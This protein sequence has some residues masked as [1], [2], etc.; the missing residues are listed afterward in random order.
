MKGKSVV[1]VARDAAPSRCFTRL[2]ESLK[3]KGIEAVL[4]VGDGKLINQDQEEIEEAITSSRIVFLGMSSTKE[5]AEVEIIAGEAA[6]KNNIPFGFYGDALHSWN[7]ARPGEFFDG[8]A[9]LA[10]FYFGLTEKDAQDARLVFPKAL[11][12][13]TGNPLRE[14]MIFPKLPREEVRRRLGIKGNEKLI[15]SGGGKF[16]GGNLACWAIIMQELHHLK[17]DFD[18]QLVLSPH[19]GDRVLSAFDQKENKPLDV[20]EELA[21][22]SP[23]PTRV[24]KNMMASE[25]VPGSDLVIDPFTSIALEAAALEIPVIS[26]RLEILFLLKEKRSG[27]RIVEAID[28]GLSELVY[29]NQLKEAVKRLLTSE[30][31]DLM[32]FR[33]KKFFPK[34]DKR[35]EAIGKMVEAIN[36]FIK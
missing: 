7:R 35:G 1:L 26:L 36:S 30:G 33:Q 2:E 21:S 22:Y 13:G 11:C 20:Y 15:F 8:I 24:E 6:I 14:E 18:F 29:P 27:T 31:S 28:E 19:P 17:E 3:L 10:A 9:P 16:I 5:L 32:R 34:V 25:I 23:V 12:L 4:F